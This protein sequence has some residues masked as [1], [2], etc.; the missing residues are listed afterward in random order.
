MVKC[1]EKSLCDAAAVR[2]LN[3]NFYRSP[4]F[5]NVFFSLSGTARGRWGQH[6][7]PKPL[8]PSSC[9]LPS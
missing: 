5:K 9:P 2:K 1:A 6:K 8:S 4:R 7:D 3:I